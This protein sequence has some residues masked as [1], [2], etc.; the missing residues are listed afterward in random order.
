MQKVQQLARRSR[1]KR[2]GCSFS[3]EEWLMQFF[4]AYNISRSCSAK[5][6][7]TSNKHKR[8]KKMRTL[9]R[10]SNSIF[11]SPSRWKQIKTVLSPASFVADSHSCSENC[12]RCW[13]ILRSCNR[14]VGIALPWLMLQ[15]KLVNGSFR[16][17][18]YSKL[19]GWRKRVYLTSI[20]IAISQPMNCTHTC[21]RA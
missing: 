19:M 6:V 8:R 17:A 12:R 16:S 14:F 7:N 3:R 5:Q 1:T 20:L 4:S 10:M 2:S 18:I 9:Y 11:I 13:W 15:D 21:G